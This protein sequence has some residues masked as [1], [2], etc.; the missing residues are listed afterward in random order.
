MS[1]KFDMAIIMEVVLLSPA[2]IK[3]KGKKSSLV[4]D[5]HGVKTAADTILL[6]KDKTSEVDK[7]KIEGLRLSI[8]GPGE[9]EVQGI[10]I[11]AERENNSLFYNITIDGIE[12]LLAS[13]HALSRASNKS[14]VEAKDYQMLVLNL[15]SEIESSVIAKISPKVVI[16]YGDN[17][18]KL[19]SEFADAK[20]MTKYSNVL[21][22]LPEEMETVLLE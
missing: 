5:P 7:A 6:L 14:I 4:V 16:F 9:Y 21:E 20:K 10:K 3:I 1:K 2:S 18:D 8:K 11:S 12:V 22:K 13:A 15:D 17:K 19:P